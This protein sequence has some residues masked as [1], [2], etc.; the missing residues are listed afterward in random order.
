[1]A[2]SGSYDTEASQV[3]VPAVEPEPKS[4]SPKKDEIVHFDWAPGM[5][6]NKQFKVLK[7]LGDGTFGRVLLV[8]G[9]TAQEPKMAVKV[10]RNVEKYIRNAKRE[11]D[12]LK[13]IQAADDQVARGCVR[14]YQ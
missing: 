9:A 11:A 8:E 14:M 4:I 12:I 7:L 6:L 13:D 10:I 5:L 2:S 1:M 3:T